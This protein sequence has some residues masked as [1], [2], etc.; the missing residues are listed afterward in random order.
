MIINNKKMKITQSHLKRLIKEELQKILQEAE[1]NTEVA[2]DIAYLNCDDSIA[3]EFC[4]DL[5]NKERVDHWVDLGDDPKEIEKISSS[6]KKRGLSAGMVDHLMKILT[7]IKCIRAGPDQ[8]ETVQREIKTI[9]SVIRDILG[10]DGEIQCS[11]SDEDESEKLDH[12]E[13]VQRY[14]DIGYGKPSRD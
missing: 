14:R 10:V 9:V 2:M 13:R 6:F 12:E 5:F 3:G 8:N 4:D 11:P 1:Q 7:V